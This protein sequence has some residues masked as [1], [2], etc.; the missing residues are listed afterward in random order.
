MHA[1]IGGGNWN[2]GVHDGSRTVN[3]NNYPWNVNTNIGVWCVC[4][5]FENCQIGGAMACQQG[6]FDN[7]LLN[8][9][10]AIPSRANRANLKQRSQIVAKAKEVWRKH[11]L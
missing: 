8:S 9:Q 2:N 6:L 1:L 4:D 11:Y 7:H 3:C 5:Y 10:T